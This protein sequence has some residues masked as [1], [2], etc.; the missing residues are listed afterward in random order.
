[1]LYAT[2]RRKRRELGKQYPPALKDSDRALDNQ[3]RRQFNKNIEPDTSEET[4]L[5]TKFAKHY[6]PCCGTSLKSLGYDTAMRVH[7][8]GTFC[9]VRNWSTLTM[10]VSYEMREAR[11]M[12]QN[13]RRLKK[14]K[15]TAK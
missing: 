7:G 4:F 8:P 5:E 1:M 3:P 14:L 12:L 2:L 6:C 9:N 13:E 10:K 11:I 15:V